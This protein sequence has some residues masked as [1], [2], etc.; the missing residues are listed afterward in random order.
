MLTRKVQQRKSMLAMSLLNDDSSSGSDDD[1]H[2]SSGSSRRNST[3]DANVF[4]AAYYSPKDK[5]SFAE[6]SRYIFREQYRKSTEAVFEKDLNTGSS[7][8]RP[9]LNA[10]EFKKKYRMSREALDFITEIIK[11]DDVFMNKRGPK[12]LDPMYQLMVLLDY[13]RTDGNG[14]NNAKQRAYFHKGNGTMDNCRR[15]A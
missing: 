5:L 13:L 1:A 9:W 8:E 10:D 7:E 4:A 6:K 12:Q 11:D 2:G 14:A 15:R 3:T